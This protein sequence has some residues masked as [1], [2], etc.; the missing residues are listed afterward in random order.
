M[1]KRL[2]VAFEGIDFAGKTTQVGLLKKYLKRQGI[3]CSVVEF[4]DSKFP[5]VRFVK[6]FSEGKK[7]DSK[8]KNF[9][10]P[11]ATMLSTYSM[12]VGEILHTR[13]GHRVVLFDRSVY[14]NY[15]LLYSVWGSRSKAERYLSS[16]LVQKIFSTVAW[17]DVVIH[18]D[19]SVEEA[20]NR[21]RKMEIKRHPHET[22]EYMEAAKKAFLNLKS[23]K[24]K[25]TSPKK[26]RWITIDG[27]QPIRKVHKDILESLK[28][29]L[30]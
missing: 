13:K 29:D 16:K 4:F 3:L 30:S 11:F 5:F 12:F 6:F 25:T 2:V 28:G 17:P 18:L 1:K 21:A 22:P 24:I 23:G 9:T 27:G 8:S 19:V 15:A 20:I 7:L 26:A 10:V 14:S